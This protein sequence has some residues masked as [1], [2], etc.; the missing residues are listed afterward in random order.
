MTKIK[1]CKGAPTKLNPEVE[2]TIC[3]ALKM[4]AYL[5]T[6]IAYA[7]ISKHAFYD[8]VK[9]GTK[10]INRRAKVDAERESE[11]YITLEQRSKEPYQRELERRR[12]RDEEDKVLREQE[13]AY[14]AFSDRTKRA[15][16]N[17]ELG[18]L[19]VIAKAAKGGLVI[20]RSVTHHEDGTSTTV[21]KYARPEW[22]AAAWALERKNPERWGRRQVEVVGKDG[23]PLEV[24]HSWADAIK[25]TFAQV[26]EDRKE[27]APR[28]T[29][30]KIIDVEDCE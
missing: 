11:S 19:G 10:E 9:R 21:E 16:A 22:T 24:K 7:G 4:G 27:D 14:A 1:K 29:A 5:E 3:N 20:G 12:K 18:Y 26:Q 17:G 8:W 30:Q 28:L 13:G 15:M 23:K 6:A 2:E 25:E